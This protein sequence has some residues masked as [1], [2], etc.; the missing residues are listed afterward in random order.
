MFDFT[1]GKHTDFTGFLI[2]SGEEGE[3]WYTVKAADRED[4]CD[5]CMNPAVYIVD[6]HY[7]A[8][9]MCQSCAVEHANTMDTPDVWHHPHH[10]VRRPVSVARGKHR[11][12]DEFRRVAKKAVAKR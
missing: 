5:F 9:P 1:Y 2:Q 10:Q 8:L 12:Q 4:D 11:G 3:E 7:S 6:G